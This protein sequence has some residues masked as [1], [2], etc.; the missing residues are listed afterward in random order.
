MNENNGGN[1]PQNDKS[2]AA[3]PDLWVENCWADCD[4]DYWHGVNFIFDIYDR[5]TGMTYRQVSAHLEDGKWGFLDFRE[6]VR[7]DQEDRGVGAPASADRKLRGLIGFDPGVWEAF[8]QAVFESVSVWAK[9]LIALC[10]R[11]IGHFKDFDQF[12]HDFANNWGDCEEDDC[13]ICSSRD[14]EQK[15]PGSEV[16]PDSTAVN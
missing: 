10:E 13:E 16:S 11:E 15:Q 6:T 7:E 3:E 5:R 8:Q 14:A 1:S 12:R 4:G 2:Q 9:S